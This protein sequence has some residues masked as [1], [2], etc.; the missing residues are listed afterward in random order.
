MSDR[1]LDWAVQ[2][3][4]HEE[5]ARQIALRL[6]RERELLGMLT[7]RTNKTLTVDVDLTVARTDEPLMLRI[8]GRVY[9]WL[10]IER[11]DSSLT[12]RL[13]QTD[14][15]LSD[16]FTA[17]KGA[18]ISQHDFVDIVVSNPAGVGVCRFVVGYWEG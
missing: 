9:R 18:S 10:T 12:Y 6:E 14:G 3:A 7:A 13:R 15:T 11:C 17:Y 8:P 2:L 1:I 5:L 16:V 4:I